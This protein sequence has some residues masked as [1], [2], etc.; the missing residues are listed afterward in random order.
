MIPEVYPDEENNT[1]P[2]K[3]VNAITKG[4]IPMNE[5]AT[6]NPILV[7]LVVLLSLV[8]ERRGRK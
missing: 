2:I 8:F 5:K 1:S 6:G 7:L 4:V 3:P